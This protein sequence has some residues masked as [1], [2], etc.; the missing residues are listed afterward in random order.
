MI[1]VTADPFEKLIRDA[2]EDWLIDWYA[3]REAALPHFREVL[4]RADNAARERLGGNGP[5]LTPEAL[6]D[7]HSRNP[8]KVRAFLQVMG[9]IASPHILVMVWRIL[10]GMGIAAIRMEYDAEGKFHLY[11]TL[12]SPRVDGTPEEEYE[13]NDI[14][15]SVILRHLGR[16]RM[17]SQGIFDGF[18][19]LNLKSER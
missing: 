4:A 7:M 18:Y 5:R 8:H 13:S 9:S 10:Q 1:S 14:D 2:G 15:D 16:I 3:P 11:V 6:I 17:G 19:A 12:S